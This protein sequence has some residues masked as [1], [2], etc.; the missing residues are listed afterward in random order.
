MAPKTRWL[1]AICICLRSPAFPLVEK[2]KCVPNCASAIANATLGPSRR[3][4]DK[5]S[6]ANAIRRRKMK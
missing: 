6:A 5:P 2:K 3:C 1:I 4:R